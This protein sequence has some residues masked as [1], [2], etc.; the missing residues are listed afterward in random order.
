MAATAGL[1]A[2]GLLVTGCSSGQ[3]S[4]TAGQESAVNGS[5]ANVN[6]IALR[7][8]LIQAVQTG[9]YLKPGRTVP[10]IFVAVNTSADVNDKLVGI[11]SDIGSVSVTGPTSI[12]AASSLIVGSADGQEA[13]TPMGDAPATA[14]VVT[15]DQ[16]IANG[17]TYNFTFDFEKAGQAKVAVPISAGG[18]PRQEAA[19]AHG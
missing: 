8:V 9:D 18:A 12:P 13:V 15:L 5:K 17:L 2:A 7:N 11:T 10:L 6:N 19:A 14:A 16:P 1:A 4:Q 3:I